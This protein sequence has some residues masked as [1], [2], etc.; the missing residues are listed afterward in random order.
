MSS[1]R[2]LQCGTMLTTTR[3]YCRV[4]RVTIMLRRRATCT[5]SQL[6]LE[7]FNI[8]LCKDLLLFRCLL[9]EHS[10]VQL[11]FLLLFLKVLLQFGNH[12]TINTQL[13]LKFSYL[14]FLFRERF[15]NFYQLVVIAT[16]LANASEMVI[17]A[18]IHTYA[19]NSCDTN[20]PMSTKSR[21]D[22]FPTLGKY[23][24]TCPLTSAH[25]EGLLLTQHCN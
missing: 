9:A 17:L 14:F 4:I 19:V 1:Y 11:V 5:T 20:R 22:H 18:L 15:M 3:A 2:F 7:L 10:R 6:A 23:Q 21:L 8:F 16:F 13:L 25:L 24:L 12:V